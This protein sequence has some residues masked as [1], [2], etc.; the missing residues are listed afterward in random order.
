[1]NL[2]HFIYSTLLGLSVSGSSVKT[3]PS[4]DLNKYSGQWYEVAAIPQS[5]QKKCVK[6]TMAQYEIEKETGY[7]KVLNTCTEANGNIK[8]AEG[9]AQVVDTTSNSKLKVTFVK[10]INWV[11]TFGGD[12]WVI[13]L[14]KDYKWAVVGAPNAD[15]A[16]ILSRTQSLPKSEYVKANQILKDNGYDTCQILTSIQ[17]TGLQ[18]RTPLCEFVK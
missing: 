14:E 18:S 6:N 17:D 10:I 15:Y 2:T 13:G 4:V 9:R 8:V 11:F 16:W 12:Y 1:M 3:V 7:V 5:F